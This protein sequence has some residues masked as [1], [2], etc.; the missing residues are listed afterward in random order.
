MSLRKPILSMIQQASED[1]LLLTLSHT[2]LYSL[3]YF[4]DNSLSW[5]I[6]ITNPF[7]KSVNKYD[8]ILNSDINNQI[9]LNIRWFILR[10]IYPLILI[11]ITISF[12]CFSFK[13]INQSRGIK[14][15][16]GIEDD[17]NIVSKFY[18]LISC[19]KDTFYSCL[20]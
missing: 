16:Q 6:Y 11:V 13:E 7:R 18:S 12:G 14:L 9:T 17:S 3:I 20:V 1:I 4:F 10:I 5:R 15:S 8:N 19:I 2:F